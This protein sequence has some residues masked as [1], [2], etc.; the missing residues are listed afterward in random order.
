LTIKKPPFGG[1]YFQHYKWLALVVI[2]YLIAKCFIGKGQP[3][4]R[5][6]G[7][8]IFQ[9][10]FYRSLRQGIDEKI[11]SRLEILRLFDLFH[12]SGPHRNALSRIDGGGGHWKGRVGPT[13]RYVF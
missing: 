2:A 10:I 5:V 9:A 11:F 4:I 12:S 7:R 13:Q 8:R 6:E 1:F 3:V